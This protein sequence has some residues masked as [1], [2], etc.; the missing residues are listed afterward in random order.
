M[1][2]V[3]KI[4]DVLIQII[5][6]GVQSIVIAAYLFSEC[7]LG[8]SLRHSHFPVPLETRRE[9]APGPTEVCTTTR[10]KDYANYI[11]ESLA[12]NYTVIDP[13]IDFSKYSCDGWRN[14]HDYRPEQISTS[15]SSNVSDVTDNILRSLLEGQ[16]IENP[17]VTGVNKTF[18]MANFKKMKLVYTTCKNEDAIEADGIT[19]LLK[20][21]ADFQS[22]YPRKAPTTGSNSSNQ[23]LTKAVSWLNRRNVVGLVSS[24]VVVRVS[25]TLLVLVGMTN[26]IQADQMNPDT[27][28]ITVGTSQRQ[29]AKEYYQNSAI[30]ANYTLAIAQTFHV[31]STGK[32]YDQEPI[33]ASKNSSLFEKAQRIVDLEALIAKNLAE[34]AQAS[35]IKVC[36]LLFAVCRGL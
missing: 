24:F 25:I 35:D 29:L 12:P 13:C 1:Y 15:V 18:D 23:E 19:P 33:P 6:K 16:Y 9:P 32:S 26:Y 36:L 34:T 30:L 11:L 22:V 3:T 27:Q 4:A 17:E 10:C 7:I 8:S 31:M 2:D 21:L 20:M 14:N 5:M 28:I